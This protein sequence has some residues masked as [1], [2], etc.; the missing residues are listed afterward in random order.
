MNRALEQQVWERARSFC[1]YC[2]FSSQHAEAP[3]QVD[4]V[5]AQKHGGETVPE[6]LALSCYNCN[7]YKGPNI[8]GIDPVSGKM[9][10]LFNPR[11]DKWADHFA[12]QGPVLTGRTAVGRATIQVLWINHPLR[13]ETRKWL[14]DA[15]LFP[16]PA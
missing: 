3:F 7:S 1:E 8:A 6:N 11:R 16:P 14:I 4:H 10:R 13:V 15:K 9:V 2:R 5:V 12:W